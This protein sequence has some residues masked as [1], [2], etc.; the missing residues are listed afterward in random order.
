MPLPLLLLLLSLLLSLLLPLTTAQFKCATDDDCSLNGL[1]SPSTRLCS[2]DAGW[3]SPDCGAL[4]LH[5]IPH[6]PSGYNLTSP[7]HSTSSWGG[8]ILHDPHTPSLFHLFAAEFTAHCGLDAWSPTSR[9]VRATSTT[10]P[11]GPYAFAQ[12]VV[13][14]FAHNPTVIYSP[15]DRLYLLYHIGCPVSPPPRPA[16]P[17]R[18]PATAA[19]R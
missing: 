15:A 16:A 12:E 10:G 2:C 7:P 8:R 6:S 13:A 4:D 17:P 11:L 5:P 1:C 14:A 18:C 19:T 3:R 9:V